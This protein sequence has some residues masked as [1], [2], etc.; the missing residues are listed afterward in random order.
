MKF[1]EWLNETMTSTGDVAGFARM[2]IP[3]VRRKW[4]DVKDDKKKKIK[5]QPQV[6]ENYEGD[7]IDLI[8]PELQ[9]S[10][11]RSGGPGG[12][13]VNKVNTKAVL[14]WNVYQSKFWN[15]ATPEAFGRFIEK[16]KNRIS[17]GNMLVLT[18]TKT[19]N[20]LQN[21]EDVIN[22]LRLMIQEAMTPPVQ[23]VATKP[24]K[25]SQNRRMDD[26]SKHSQKKNQR[27]RNNIF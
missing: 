16:N 13:N 2:S 18:S 21:K 9:I 24:S 25:R 11:A 3:L 5:M 22:K 26:K 27:R 1:K 7:P 15:T 20:Q 23:R 12:Q 19:R 10:F 6:K 4:V 8:A 14:H 17:K